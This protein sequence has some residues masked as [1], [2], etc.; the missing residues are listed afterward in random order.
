[1]FLN[2]HNVV[3]LTLTEV[4]AHMLAECLIWI[5]NVHLEMPNNIICH[6]VGNHSRFYSVLL[7]GICW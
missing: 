3:M 4:A 2:R 7:S 5:D 6:V 1:M